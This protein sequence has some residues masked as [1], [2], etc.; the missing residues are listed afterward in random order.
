MKEQKVEPLG[1]KSVAEKS[2]RETATHIPRGII[3]WAESSTRDLDSVTKLLHW[4]HQCFALK[5]QNERKS[6]AV[7]LRA[8]HASEKQ[9]DLC[10]FDGGEAWRL[11]WKLEFHLKLLL[12][13]CELKKGVKTRVEDRHLCSRIVSRSLSHQHVQ[14]FCLTPI[15]FQI[16]PNLHHHLSKQ[17]LISWLA[18][19]GMPPVRI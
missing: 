11:M 4:K 12:F 14:E 3:W 15:E 17:E 13:A 1:M 9:H 8:N 10:L 16:L 2:G 18:A 6:E 19:H 7:A 5:T